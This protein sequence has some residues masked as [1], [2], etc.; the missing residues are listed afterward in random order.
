MNVHL[1]VGFFILGVS[2]AYA[3]DDDKPVT[4]LPGFTRT[5]T[6]FLDA[7]VQLLSGLQT[8]ILT[9]VSQRAEFSTYGLA[10]NIQPLIELRRRYLL[11]LT[12][13]GGAMGRFKQAEQNS[14]RQLDLYREGAASKRNLQVQQAQWQTDKALLDAS[15]VQGK[16]IVDESLLNWGRKLTEWALSTDADQLQAFLSGSKT[17]L[18]ITLPVNKRL[19][20]TIKSI[21]VEASGNRSAAINAELISAALHT[22]NLAQGESYFFQADGSHIRT[23]M[24]VVAWIPE[25]G[26][27]R[28]GVNIPESALIWY[29]DQ[30]FVYIKTADEQFHRRRIEQFSATADGYFVG[31]SIKPGEFLVT[32][33]AQMLLSEELKGQIPNEGD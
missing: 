29:L 31:N 26:E 17:L 15:G 11:A 3:D 23:G 22:D 5:G 6:V 13:Q 10:V 25:Q 1:I 19:A 8:I 16:S 33:G 32:A 7:K 12:E 2:L 20:N 18:Q 14:K 27:N 24:R 9:P 30:A 28:I 4:Q 21:K